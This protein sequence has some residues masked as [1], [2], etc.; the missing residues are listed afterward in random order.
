MFLIIKYIQIVSCIYTKGT[1]LKANHNKLIKILF[2]K[3]LYFIYQRYDFESKSQLLSCSYS[4][5]DCCISY[6]KGTTLKANHNTREERCCSC[7]LYFIY[8]RYDFESKSQQATS[9]VKLLCCCISY[10]KGTILKA[11]HND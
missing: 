9:A 6:T 3:L 1:T 7:L 8:Q 5:I 10:T 11:N 2:D 4:P